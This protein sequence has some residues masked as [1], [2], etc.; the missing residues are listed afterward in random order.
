M[1]PPAHV[2]ET[3]SIAAAWEVTGHV[4]SVLMNDLMQRHSSYCES[5]LVEGRALSAQGRGLE[6]QGREGW[7]QAYKELSPGDQLSCMMNMSSFLLIRRKRKPVL[8]TLAADQPC[9]SAFHH[10]KTGTGQK[11]PPD[12]LPATTTTSQ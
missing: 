4:G 5:V 7:R 10:E 9:P 11:P 2:L 3:V 8:P 1:L 6:E 12:D